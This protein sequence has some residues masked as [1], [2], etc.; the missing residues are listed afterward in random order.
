M[1]KFIAIAADALTLLRGVTIPHI[2]VVLMA[3]G[4]RSYE[5]LLGLLFSG[6]ITD[7]YDGTLARK[8]NQ[9]SFVGAHE[10]IFDLTFIVFILIYAFFVLPPLYW[11][12]YLIGSI[13]ILL[14][15]ASVYGTLRH[16]SLSFVAGIEVPFAPTITAILMIYGIICGTFIDKILV[17]S[18]VVI[19][20]FHYKIGLR[21]KQRAAKFISSLPQDIARAISN[22]SQK[23]SK[24]DQTGSK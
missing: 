7:F 2:I 14:A 24:E 15:G 3:L 23:N 19:G 8:A 9:Q 16:K 21:A 22:I 1:R 5:V 4:I 10:I 11:W 12:I 17:S 13:W 20:A 18:F 6:W